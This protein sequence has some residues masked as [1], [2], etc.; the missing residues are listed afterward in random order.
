VTFTWIPFRAKNIHEMRL[1]LGEMFSTAPG[2]ALNNGAIMAALAMA[3]AWSW[4]L[5]EEHVP[6]GGWAQRI[7]LPVKALAYSAIGIAVL[8]LGS[9]APKTFIYFRF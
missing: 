3:A 4:Q 7:P 5:A 1:V 8:V 9:E 2:P 6:L